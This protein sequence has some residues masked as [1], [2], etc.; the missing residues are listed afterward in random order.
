MEVLYFDNKTG[1]LIHIY[2][3]MKKTSCTY[4]TMQISLKY[5]VDLYCDDEL[6]IS[7]S[8]LK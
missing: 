7:G 5:L 1:R 4:R 6:I 2:T 3:C 8:F